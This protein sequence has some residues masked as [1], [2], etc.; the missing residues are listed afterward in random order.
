MKDAVTTVPRAIGSGTG[1]PA[2][3]LPERFA[4]LSKNDPEFH[5]ALPDHAIDIAKTKSGLGLAQMVATCMEGYADRP[6]LAERATELVID[7]VTGRRQRNLLKHYERISYRELWARS[8]ALAACW[9]HDDTHALRAGDLLCIMSFGDIDFIT[10]DLATIHNGAVI[11]PM[12][13]GGSLQQAQALFDEVA[14][15]WLATSIDHLGDAVQ[16]ILA[17]RRTAGML[18]LG[19]H[20]DDDGHLERLA[21][22]RAELAAAGFD[23]L[24]FTLNEA[25]A[26]GLTLAPAPLFADPSSDDR[27]CIITYTSGSTGL[28]KGAMIAERTIKPIWQ[29]V[30]TA[31]L[32]SILYMPLNHSAGRS[33][34]HSTL[35]C[36]GAGY[37]TARSDL[38]ELFD[39]IRTA[40]P[41]VMTMVPRLC[42]MI[43]QQYLSRLERARGGSD[44]AE[45]LRRRVMLEIR[46]SVLGGR[47]ISCIFSAAPLAPD[48]RRFIEECLGFPMID[49]YG[50][51]EIGGVIRDTQLLYPPVIEHKLVD[52]PELGYFLTDKPSPRGEL[53]VKTQH[54]MLGYFK[55]PDTTA[56]VFDVEGFY[57]SGDIMAEIAPGRLVY[58][59]RRNNVLKLS[60]GEFVAI[61]RLETIFSNGHPAIRQAYL[62]GTSDRAF[63]VAV[64]VPDAAAL[65]RLG[66]S[67]DELAVRAAIR[68]AVDE[69]ARREKLSPYEVPR[70][71]IVEY[72]PFS[73]E[74]GLL[75]G[76]GKYQRPKLKAIYAERLEILYDTIAAAR[77]D[78]MQALRRDGLG[79]PVAVTVQRV[80]R[81]TLGL[82]ELDP[83]FPGSFAD[84]GGDSL[85][86]LS[87][88]LLLEEIYDVEIPV[89]IINNPSGGLQQL[90]AFIKRARSGAGGGVSFASIHGRDA[91]HIKVT[92]LVLDRFLDARLLACAGTLPPPADDVR[93]ILLTGANGYLG[94]F[95]CLEWLERMAAKNGRVICIGRGRDA[96]DARRR[97]LSAFDTG[98]DALNRHVVMLAESCLD[99]VPGDI[100]EP[101]FGLSKAAWTR[102]A[103][104]VDLIVHPAAL[105]NHVLPYQQLFGPNVI[106]TAELIRLALSQRLKP[107]IF[108]ST[109]AAAVGAA[110]IM[111]E[112]ADVR[113]ASPERELSGGGY[114]AGYANSKWAGE[115][116]LRDAHERFGLPVTVFRSD[117]I[118]SHSRYRGQI[119]V[120]DMFTRWLVSVVQTGI[121][122]LSFYAGPGSPHY[123]GLPVDFIA[124]AIAELGAGGDR[125]FHTYHV[126]NPEDDGVSL[127]RFIDWLGEAGRPIDRID[128]Y[129]DWFGRFETALRGLSEEQRQ[130]TS[131]PLLHQMREPMPASFG[132][133]ISAARFR[134]AVRNRSVGENGEIPSLSREFIMKCLADIVQ[135]RLVEDRI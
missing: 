59:D 23:G 94:R 9:F 115:V 121:A 37:F 40:R 134:E 71:F 12:P 132:T 127:D 46:E 128:D 11:V 108:V 30:S 67:D 124:R 21:A 15:K 33:T 78:Q 74:N 133:V 85:S 44:D 119:N 16:L 101:G 90:A 111:D 83:A 56:Q 77:N 55:R 27:M 64:I 47:L 99:V 113:H 79:L 97:I 95:L 129:A 88:A 135:L 92:D 17:S 117:M 19:Y 2:L 63:L 91:T 81:T 66:V 116:L 103:E 25:V 31:P 5:A 100:S 4:D 65:R 122:P 7:P 41:T 112:D 75:T 43:Y 106:G 98:D 93:T 28:P 120:P 35:G 76:V 84:L 102:L 69:I 104:T 96:G 72:E 49:S 20:P 22:A 107:L 126:L 24:F 3:S 42:E 54:V 45:E 14:P 68:D 36:G 13:T 58:V 62:Y 131:L 87:C 60:Q 109:I 86:A 34:V 52:V 114:A 18:V 39:D 70:D 29:V 110:G 53:L 118:L 51:T 6:A 10:V 26:R 48:L 73:S 32:I 57:K 1:T 82:E 89:A 61:S 38:S 123:A 8:K 125:G 105:V 130:H 80:V 50:A